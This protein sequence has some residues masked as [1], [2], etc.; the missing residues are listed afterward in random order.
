MMRITNG[1]EIQHP[2]CYALFSDLEETSNTEP[3][4]VKM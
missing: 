4:V 3:F 1:K 2:D